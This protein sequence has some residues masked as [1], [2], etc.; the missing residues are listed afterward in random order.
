MNLVRQGGNHDRL[1]GAD[2]GGG[3]L[4]EDAGRVGKPVS[5]LL[6]VKDV[7]GGDTHHLGREDRRQEPGLLERDH[8]LGRLPRDE[9]RPVVD[10]DPFG[11]DASVANPLLGLHADDL[12][13]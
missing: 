7:V 8:D 4:D 2:D 12:H 9:G 5:H 13:G 3:R 11:L 10:P 1:A 6:G